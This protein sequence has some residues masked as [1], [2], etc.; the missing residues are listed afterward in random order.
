MTAKLL[1]IQANK[2]SRSIAILDMFTDGFF[3]VNQKATKITMLI[4][5]LHMLS[6]STEALYPFAIHRFNTQC[7]GSEVV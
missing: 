2:I 7:Y 4:Q 6:G 5:C 1:V 3:Q